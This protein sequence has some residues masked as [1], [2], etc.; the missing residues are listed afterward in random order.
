[1]VSSIFVAH[2]AMEAE[3]APPST[4]EQPATPDDD[5]VSPSPGSSTVSAP[6]REGVA[7]SPSEMVV[8]DVGKGRRGSR[9]WEVTEP[10]TG[11]LPSTSSAALPQK[12]S[13]MPVESFMEEG[14]VNEDENAGSGSQTLEV[15]LIASDSN[16]KL[17]DDS[18]RGGSN[19]PDIIASDPLLRVLRKP[20]EARTDDELNLICRETANVKFFRQIEDPKLHLELCRH[21]TYQDVPADEPI[22]TQ[23]DEGTTF[24]II[25]S[26]AVKVMVKDKESH[27][28]SCVC[29]LEDGDSFGELALLGN[30]LRA[31]TVQ[32]SMPTQLLLVEKHAYDESLQ[33]MH[34]SELEE[35][36]RFLQ[37]IF[38]FSQWTD[39]DLL[40]LTKVLTRKSFPKNTTV[41]PQ[42]INTDNMYFVVSGRLR[43]LK[44]M[45]LSHQLTT[46]LANTRGGCGVQRLVEDGMSSS[47]SVP[48][49]TPSP[50]A[51]MS[52]ASSRGM[53]SARGGLSGDPSRGFDAISPP[54][55]P[56]MSPRSPGSPRSRGSKGVHSSPM[57][58]LG[59]L[60][61]YQYFGELAL[62]EGLKK[63]K[64]KS[65]I[66]HSAS[67]VS[68]TPVEVL[69]L[70]KYDFYHLID[71][72]TQTLMRNY[73]DKFYFD[74]SAIRA[75]IKEQNR[76]ENYK[77]DLL[78]E[79][80]PSGGMMGRR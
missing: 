46:K 57:L 4:V 21:I 74:E 80:R 76:W 5:S 48:G 13:P 55:S 66:A 15:K 12:Q 3:A 79:I 49:G 1:M 58:E 25:Y 18:P 8:K 16:V 50:R 72:Q 60:G 52:R 78:R 22:F 34:E 9:R 17:V 41:I 7:L 59:E 14:K 75:Q 23:G 10:R 73:A 69:L 38:I 6:M 44:S 51:L 20:S 77:K 64:Y 70:S 30:G 19:D 43:V 31:A 26:G 47:A 27:D 37:R 61:M 71:Q 54:G 45:E 56:L 28:A 33:R 40:R 62:L 29:V 2:F 11:L 63:G 35:R 67:V 53:N 36:M 32:P 39:E 65:N 68:T 24:Y 42:G